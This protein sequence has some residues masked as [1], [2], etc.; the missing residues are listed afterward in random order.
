MC[1]Q[2]K[3]SE[4]SQPPPTDIQLAQREDKEEE[5]T[6]PA[7]R[8]MGMGIWGGLGNLLSSSVSESAQAIG[9]GIGSVVSTVE[10][11]LGVPSP[12]ELVI[13]KEEGEANEKTEKENPGKAMLL[14][15]HM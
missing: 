15:A 9:R 2:A 10:E 14:L 8:R 4:P 7:V 5:K 12:Q 3:S 13:E 11:T 6:E 1:Q